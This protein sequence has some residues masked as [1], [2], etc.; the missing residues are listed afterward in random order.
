VGVGTVSRVLNDSPLVSDATRERVQKVIEELDYRPS[1]VARALSLG[2]TS[3]V[4]VVAPFFTR[5]SAVLR[6]R[7]L[8]DVVNQSDFDVVLYAVET[9]EQRDERFAL[10][11]A[12]DRY[13]GV[14]VVSLAVDESTLAD[15]RET[16]VPVVF[17]DRRAPGLPHVFVDDTEGGRLATAHLIELG[18]RR[19]AFIGDDFDPQFGFTSSA[20]RGVGYR[21]A[22]QQAGLPVRPDYFRLA[23]HGR[24]A[25]TAMTSA[26]LG[27]AD[28]PTAIFAAS[29]LQA[30][31]VLEA[32]RA[33]GIRVPEELSV[34]GFDDIEVAPY[35]GL[36]TVRQPLYES[37]V[38]EPSCCWDRSPGTRRTVH[39]WCSS[40]SRS[41]CGAR[42]LHRPEANPISRMR[43]S[44]IPSP[45]RSRRRRRR[46]G[47]V[48]S[49]PAGGP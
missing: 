13:A 41:R 5:P 37:G 23:E 9:P 12:S 7:G 24:K 30:L 29:D 39:P 49:S 32:A 47:G 28:P 48:R 40:L 36:T 4:A 11:T 43:G 38:R 22:M 15:L 2:R 31:G 45:S 10:A 6:L 27:L 46:L 25:A 3:T 17:V 16:T 19:V 34:V 35:M 21:R 44:R 33:S 20:D 18:H 8:I 1:S 42:R 14:I 26:L